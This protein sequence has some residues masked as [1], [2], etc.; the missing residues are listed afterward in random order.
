MDMTDVL[1][2][3]VDEERVKSKML[4]GQVDT[5][6]GQVG[7]LIEK[8]GEPDPRTAAIQGLM[9]CRSALIGKLNSTPANYTH[10]AKVLER[11]R[12]ELV[13]IDTQVEQILAG[14]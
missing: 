2:A 6:K 10:Y 1:Q 7:A 4:Q 8:V 9:E 5:L 13:R 11:S 14:Q 3:E 12:A